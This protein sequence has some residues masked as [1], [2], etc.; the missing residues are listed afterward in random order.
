MT[1]TKIF[2]INL[3]IYNTNPRKFSTGL[4]YSDEN[5][6]EIINILK[7]N[8]IHYTIAYREHEQPNINETSTGVKAISDDSNGKCDL[9]KSTEP[10]E[11]KL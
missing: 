11:E 1:S 9:P 5:L 8:S 3:T 6:E 10:P 4:I 2:P 7:K